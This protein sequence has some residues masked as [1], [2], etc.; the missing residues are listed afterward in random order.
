MRFAILNHTKYRELLRRCYFK[1]IARNT[2]NITEQPLTEHESEKKLQS[3]QICPLD[4]TTD[5]PGISDEVK[6]EEAKAIKQFSPLGKVKT[7]QQ[8][9]T[10]RYI[11]VDTQS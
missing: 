9:S 3:N 5:P 10:S 1:V 6:L 4:T 2:K 8:L 11:S 7:A